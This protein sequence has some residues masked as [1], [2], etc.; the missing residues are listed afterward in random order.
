MT[1]G[2]IKWAD[3]VQISEGLMLKTSAFQIFHGDNSTFINSFD[4]INFHVL[5]SYWRSTTVSLES[6]HLIA[7]KNFTSI[8][9]LEVSAKRGFTLEKKPVIFFLCY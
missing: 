5:L 4:E 9:P 2:F 6:R 1:I 7:R 3:K 8:G